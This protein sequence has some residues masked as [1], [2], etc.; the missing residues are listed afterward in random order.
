MRWITHL[1]G[2][3]VTVTVSLALVAIEARLGLG[4]LAA[5]AMSGITVQVLKRGFG[6][7]RPWNLKTD[8]PLAGIKLPDPFS[9]PSGH[10]AAI[11]ALTVTISLYRPVLSPFLLPVAALVATSR[12]KLLVHFLGDVLAGVSIGLAG[13]IAAWALF[14]R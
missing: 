6:R 3:W 11:A 2:F 10:S 13:A 8:K 7:R 4:V 9:F 12:V 14:L 5:V 1:G